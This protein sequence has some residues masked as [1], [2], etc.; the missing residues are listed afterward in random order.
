M[1]D[2]ICSNCLYVGTA[3]KIKR[4][5]PMSWFLFPI[6]I[7]HMI[8]RAFFNKKSVCRHCGESMLMTLDSPIGSKLLASIE[9][10]VSGV[11][12]NPAAPSEENTPSDTAAPRSHE[13]EHEVPV[14]QQAP[15][16]VPTAPEHDVIKVENTNIENILPPE[17]TQRPSGRTEKQD[18]N[19]W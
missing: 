14:A 16:P 18:P 4:G 17:L 13:Q 19:D 2:L 12:A 7:I 15:S 11:L 3:R 10:D 5:K 6:N 9:K 1:T 8:I